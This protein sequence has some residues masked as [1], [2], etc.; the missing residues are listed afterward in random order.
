M[1]ANDAMNVFE[2]TYY[3]SDSGS[4]SSELNI[5]DVSQEEEKGKIKYDD[6][7][8][9]HNSQIDDDDDDDDTDNECMEDEG[10]AFSHLTYEQNEAKAKLSMV[11]DLL[12]I[13]LIN[14]KSIVVI[15]GCFLYNYFSV[16]STIRPIR[17]KI[18]QV[19]RTLHKLC[20]ILDGKLVHANDP[21]PYGLLI[22]ESNELLSGLKA[23][24]NKSKDAEQVRLKTI[25]ARMWGREKTRKWYANSSFDL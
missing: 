8:R 9:D 2:N 23:L 22:S 12:N 21:N 20:D 18:D 14:D 25:A 10:Y 16:R 19:Y 11:F 5:V 3:S 24:F 17:L 15:D 1:G 4:D 13:P 6:E 7:E